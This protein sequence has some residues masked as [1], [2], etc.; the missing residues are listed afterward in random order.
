MAVR[1]LRVWNSCGLAVEGGIRRRDDEF[2]G[3]KKTSGRFLFFEHVNKEWKIYNL[4][5]LICSCSGGYSKELTFLKSLQIYFLKQNTLPEIN[6]APKSD[7][8]NDT[9]LLGR[10]ISI[11]GRETSVP[12]AVATARRFFLDPVLLPASL[13]SLPALLP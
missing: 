2:P 8:W 3:Q 5:N 6:I 4:I 10:P 11:S 9:F 7:G 13:A 1:D 12:F